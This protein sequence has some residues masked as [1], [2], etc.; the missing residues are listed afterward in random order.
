MGLLLLL[1]LG[2]SAGIL[3]AQSSSD[4]TGLLCS[5]VQR[6]VLL[7]GVE[8]SQLVSLVGVDDGQDAGNRFA[9]VMSATREKIISQQDAPRRGV[10]RHFSVRRGPQFFSYSGPSTSSSMMRVES[11]HIHSGQFRRSTAGNLLDS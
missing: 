9:E 4:G 11:M 3:L 2:D 7:L 6:E 5:E 10:K 8:E 1:L